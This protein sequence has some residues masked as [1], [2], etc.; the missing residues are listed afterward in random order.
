M[1]ISVIRTCLTGLKGRALE[2]QVLS[3]VSHES[4][5]SILFVV[6]ISSYEKAMT[7]NTYVSLRNGQRVDDNGSTI[8]SV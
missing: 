3:C 7:L 8:T 2:K 4:F 5:L 6:Y 1:Y